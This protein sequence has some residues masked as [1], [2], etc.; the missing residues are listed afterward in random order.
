MGED[1][2]RLQKGVL[3]QRFLGAYR[4]VIPEERHEAVGKESGE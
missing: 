1:P 3:L 2:R 4:A